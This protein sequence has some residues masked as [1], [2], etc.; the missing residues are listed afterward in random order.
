MDAVNFIIG[1]A[2]KGAGDTRYLM[3]AILAASIF[4]FLIPLWIGIELFDRGI[5]F[6]WGC[7]L[8]FVFSLFLLTWLRYRQGRWQQMSVI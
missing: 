7:V 1:G 6:A 8:S 3:C 4:C 5:F 2:L